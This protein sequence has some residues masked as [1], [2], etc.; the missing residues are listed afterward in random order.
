MDESEECSPELVVSG[1][2]APE[3]LQFVEEPLDQIS[4]AI[5]LLAER[6]KRFS[7]GFVGD[8]GRR[9]LGLDLG[10]DPVGVIT[11]VG[12]NNCS[13]PEILQLISR[14]G[15]VVVLSRCDQ[16][17]ERAALFVDERVDFRGEPASATTHATISTPFFA[18]AAC[19]WTRTIEL[20]II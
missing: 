16:E 3:L 6:I 4:L 19:W 1:R 11:F 12:K 9:A 20:S 7:I 17:A 5:E 18:P 2:N 14:S 8:V 10:A 15:R 13:A